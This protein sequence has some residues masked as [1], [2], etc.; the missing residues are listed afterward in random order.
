MA[1]THPKWADAYPY[2]TKEDT[3]RKFPSYEYGMIGLVK[4][5]IDEMVLR[6]LNKERMDVGPMHIQPG[7]TIIEKKIPGVTSR[8]SLTALA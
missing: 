8:I 6:G 3:D 2:E 4:Q 5:V 7:I 1:L